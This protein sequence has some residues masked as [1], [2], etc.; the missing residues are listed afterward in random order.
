MKNAEAINWLK[1]QEEELR[2]ELAAERTKLAGYLEQAAQGFEE[3][4]KRYSDPYMLSASDRVDENLIE[5]QTL[6]IPASLRRINELVGK[7]ELLNVLRFVK[8]EA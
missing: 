3:Q 1:E 6:W 8:E 5:Q 2:Q 7:I 4:A